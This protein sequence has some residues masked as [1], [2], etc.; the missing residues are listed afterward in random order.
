[1]RIAGFGAERAFGID[2]YGSAGVTIA[3]L[4][5]SLVKGVPVQA[6]CFRIAPGG[7]IGRHPASVPQLLAVI[8]GS[9]WVSGGDGEPRPI[10]AGEAV[11]WESGEEHETWTESGLTAIV[12]EGEGVA[13]AG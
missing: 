9:G 5:A 11:W 6:A 3:P 2:A 8:E 4:T 13:P 12:I 1:M 10:G 7:R